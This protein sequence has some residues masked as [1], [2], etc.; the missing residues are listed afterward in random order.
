MQRILLVLAAAALFFCGACASIPPGRSA[1][2]S[3]EIRGGKALDGEDVEEKVATTP[4][5]KFLGLFE[6]VIYDYQIFDR[7][8]LQ[9]DLARVERYY[10]ARGFYDAHA[11]AGRVR[12]TRESHVEVEII[13]EEGQPVLTGDV[14]IAGLEGL[15]QPV[16]V[17]A[18]AATKAK[19]AHG[20][21]FD[22]DNFVAAETALRTALQDDGYAYAK[23]SRDSTVDLVLH[24]ADANFTVVPDKPAT[25]GKITIE[26][27]GS[28]PETPVRRALNLK[29]GTTY[30]ASELESAQQA[31]LDLGVFASVAMLPQLPNPPP[32]SRIVP[33]TVR[34][35]P[36][37]LRTVK[38]GAGFEIDGI[39][40]DVHALIRWEN[41]NFLGGLRSFSASF[42]PGLVFY[43]TR[44]DNFVAP[45]DVLPTERLRLELR[46]PGFLE[47]RTTGFFRPEF[48]IFPLL[49]RAAGSVDPNVPVPGYRELKG[50]LGADR[51]FWKFFYANITQNV[52]MENPFTYKGAIDPNV[53]SLFLSYPALITNFDFRDDRV[54]PHKGIYIGNEVQFAGLIGDAVDVRIQPE[55]RGYVP[56]TR[57]ITLAS[58]VKLGFLFPVNYGSH[59]DPATGQPAPGA[60][61]ADWA[62]DLQLIF[63]RGFYSGGPTSN[64]G[65]ALGDVGPHGAVPFFDP[66]L[67][68]RQY[69]KNCD[70]GSPTYSAANCAVPLKGLTLWEASLEVRFPIF[71]NFEAA[72]FC[73]TSDVSPRRTE[74]R[75]SHLHLSCGAGGRYETPVGPIRLDIGYRIVEIIGAQDVVQCAAVVNGRCV[76]DAPLQS[77]QEGVHSAIFG[78]PMAIAFGIGEAF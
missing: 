27:L 77:T 66:G 73:D 40:T 28:L 34:V 53:R 32:E 67:D 24:R 65:Y 18:Q 61:T 17:A 14:V 5:P 11:R 69:Q 71:K 41:R 68:A 7:F 51:T 52:Q 23:V 1:I 57:R 64:R 62:R 36:A 33:V 20:K 70:A 29:E 31:A 46:Q 44:I 72:V 76:A 63:F 78:L 43:P 12:T 56:L 21:P 6:G 26:G 13:V 42:R 9:R 35:E 37:K 50:A 2:E 59:I 39:K 4:S 22:E 16:I 55:I 10:R 47:A 54:H 58:K 15:P 60:A 45:T 75:L 74:I 25:F 49:L 48:N 8:V 19:L 3:V 38:I 30:S